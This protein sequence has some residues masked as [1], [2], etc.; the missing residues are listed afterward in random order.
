MKKSLLL[1]SALLLSA[2]APH[3][4]ERPVSFH[5]RAFASQ[6]FATNRGEW[7]D[8]AD[9]YFFTPSIGASAEAVV[10][11]RPGKSRVFFES[12]LCGWIWHYR[13]VLN[14]RS[15]HM[16]YHDWNANN[17]GLS[18]G[19][20]F[21]AGIH[22]RQVFN[23]SAGAL[24]LRNVSST[25]LRR[26]D[27]QSSLQG[28][29]LNGEA[30]ITGINRTSLAFDLTASFQL[31]PRLDV[32]LRGAVDTKAYPTIDA[33]HYITRDGFTRQ[34][35]FSGAPKLASVSVGLGFIP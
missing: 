26:L 29:E 22:I 23:L 8:P 31:S 28:E 33:H 11:Y 35:I 24:L 19:I 4:Q 13:A 7:N 34:Y 30:T 12:G 20:P 10:R 3:A 5:A 1:A 14:T 32:L 25:A 21:R 16:Q 17:G 2:T 18:L 27:F 15:T 6:Y 9:A